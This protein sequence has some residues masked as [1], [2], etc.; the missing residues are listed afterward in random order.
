MLSVPLKFVSELIDSLRDR[1][2]TASVLE[3]LDWSD[4]PD[5]AC[6]DSESLGL[7]AGEAQAL[8]SPQLRL[9]LALLE[10]KRNPDPQPGHWL[11]LMQACFEAGRFHDVVQLQQRG[12]LRGEQVWVLQLASAYRLGDWPAVIHTANLLDPASLP[13]GLQ[14]Q[15]IRAGIELGQFGPPLSLL[16]SL[17]PVTTQQLRQLQL[18]HL[19]H[20][21]RHGVATPEQAF[22]L[23]ALIHQLQQAELA[24]I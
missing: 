11:Q 12:A 19:L 15:I 20:G 3:A 5:S 18:L 10:F 1:L 23:L 2:A 7:L 24:S 17:Q 6:I 8:G 22:H 16:A 21:F 9:G 4:F 14:A 13:F